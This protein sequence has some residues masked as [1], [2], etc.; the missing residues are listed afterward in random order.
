MKKLTKNRSCV[1]RKNGNNII[2]KEV[3]QLYIGDL[4]AS[5]RRPL[6]KGFH[7]IEVQANETK[8]VKF[9][10]DRK[11]IEFFTANLKWEAELVGF[12][13]F[14]GGSFAVTL[15]SNFHI[16]INFTSSKKIINS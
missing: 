13:V 14:T 16:L 2:V 9:T 3:V 5:A 11:T 4:I 8:R 6:I 10:V 7:L 15:E 12:N 1:N